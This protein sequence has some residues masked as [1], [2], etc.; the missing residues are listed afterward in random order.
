MEDTKKEL[1]PETDTTKFVNID[2]ESYDIY[3]DGKLARHIEADEEQ[4]MP[5][6]V[7]QVGA[8]HLVD[9]ILQLRHDIKDTNRDTDLRKSLFSKILPDMAEEREI[10]PLTEEEFRT[11]VNT[12]LEEQGKL[13][14][15]LQGEKNKS[16]EKKDK[17]I[18]TLKE[19]VSLLE[20]SGE[21]R[22]K[23]KKAKKEKTVAS[24]DE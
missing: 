17:E 24:S 21:G 2:K 11:K 14:E 6:Y 9:R 16:E 7:A 4:I 18:E 3:I 5:L 23:T 13:I 19:K 1:N 15:G 12:Q 20:K 22:K 10:K 8:K